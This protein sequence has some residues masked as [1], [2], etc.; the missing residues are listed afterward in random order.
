ML[1][2]VFKKAVLTDTSGLNQMSS[3]ILH[4]IMHVHLSLYHCSCIVP[5]LT[6]TLTNEEGRE[7][8]TRDGL[9]QLAITI[10]Q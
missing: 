4:C 10:G 8:P 9:S 6:D 2:P 3:C 5:L 7:H 1:C